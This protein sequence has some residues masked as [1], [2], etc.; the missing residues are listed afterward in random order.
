M[1]PIVAVVF[2][3]ALS[4]LGIWE[5]PI[6]G[7]IGSGKADEVS[8]KEGAIGAFAKGVLTTILATPCSAPFLA[9]ALTWAL[10]QPPLHIYAVFT[11]VG[12]GMAS[13]YLLIGAFPR[14]IKFLPK[15][16]AWMETFKEVMG[17]V[18]LGTVIFILTFIPEKM[19]IP[20]VTFLFGLWGGCWWIGRTSPLEPLRIKALRWG[21][22]L[23]FSALIWVI[24]F[25]WLGSKSEYTLPWKPYSEAHL[26][27]LMNE[28]QT[29]LI[30]FTAD[31]CATCKTFE[32]VVLN[33][34]TVYNTVKEYDVTTLKADWT[35]REDSK[36]VDDMLTRLGS[37][38]V[39]VIVVIPDG[40]PK[41]MSIFRG[42]YTTA[43]II[44]AIEK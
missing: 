30:D 42:S 20:T 34:E 1:T 13:P 16:G 41:K 35:S 36:E 28:K 43:D 22:A 33:T 12:L 37:K 15:P 19:V 17:F 7:F 10:A 29:V 32:T 40:D 5:V 18:L 14:L 2:V 31:W 4:F 8:R 44:G 6:P 38:Q 21:E 24:A 23:V 11:A 26:E 25:S 9:T 3:M 39:P 27:Q